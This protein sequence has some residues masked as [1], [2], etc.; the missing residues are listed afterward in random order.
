MTKSTKR[1]TIIKSNYNLRSAKLKRYLKSSSDT[2]RCTTRSKKVVRKL[3]SVRDQKDLMV[4]GSA[5]MMYQFEH[6]VKYA[7]GLEFKPTFDPR[8]VHYNTVTKVG[9]NIVDPLK[10]N[11]WS[12]GV[13]MADC[14]TSMAKFGVVESGRLPADEKNICE[15]SVSGVSGEALKNRVVEYGVVVE[16]DPGKRVEIVKILIAC[17]FIVNVTVIYI[18]DT[19]IVPFGQKLD[20]KYYT[21]DNI[22]ENGHYINLIGFNEAK[23]E[24]SYINSWGENWGNG[25]YG[26][27]SYDCVAYN[28]EVTYGNIYFLVGV[29]YNDKLYSLK[30]SV[31]E[32]VG[33]IRM[34]VPVGC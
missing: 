31:P 28:K 22:I 2:I 3:F 7:S 15:T 13:T 25:G 17:G 6:V 18:N 5:S 33:C 16:P 32:G 27:V 11:V 1:Y 9:M 8:F 21:R 26:V 12:H 19:T 20:K 29:T 24:F 34:V 30:K 23:R 4:C 14:I 10:E